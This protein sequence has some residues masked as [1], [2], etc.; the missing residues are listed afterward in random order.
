MRRGKKGVK[1]VRKV[2][3]DGTVREY[4]YSRAKASAPQPVTVDG[5]IQKYRMSPEF[6]ALAPATVKHRL[7]AFD[8]LKE[9]G[10]VPVPDLRR[11]HVFDVRDALAETPGV[12]NQVLGTLSVLLKFAVDREIVDFNVAQGVK[13]LEIGQHV[14]WPEEAILWAAAPGNLIEP[15]RRA[16]MLA[17]HTG[18]RQGDCLAMCWSHY[19]GEGIAV[20][21]QKTGAKVWIP[22]HEDLRAELDTWPKVAETILTSS[23]GKPW[24]PSSF[25]PAAS[26]EIR[27]KLQ[28][29][30]LTFHG[31]RKSAAA[32][33]AEAGCSAH[34]IA[35]ITGHTSLAMVELYT[36]EARQRDL[37]SAAILRLETKRKAP[38]K[39]LH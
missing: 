25:P 17:L 1:T 24:A 23:V 13:G 22:A 39:T 7:R 20:T 36:K 18:Q 12:A 33:L 38:P 37:A 15:I 14:R 21:Q 5:L 29:A 34:E 9:L 27:G 19:D 30:G 3:A 6:K 35:S 8:K 11:R 2:L 10:T 31:L 26:K 28:L 32:R 4:V 16:I